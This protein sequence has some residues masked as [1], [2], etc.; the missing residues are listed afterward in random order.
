MILSEYRNAND[1]IVYFPSH[2]YSVHTNYKAFKRGSVRCP[3]DKTVMGIACIGIGKY[4]VAEND[5]KHT[6]AYMRWTDMLRRV[7]EL[8][9]RTESYYRNGVRVSDE[10]LCFNNF[11]DW[12][13][14][15][16]GKYDYDEN[17]LELDKDILEKNNN[18]YCPDKCVLATK[19]INMLF[20]KSK[21]SRGAMPLG[22][23]KMGNKY[24]ARMK[25]NGV[26]KHLGTYETIEE[27]F[28]SYKEA[29]EGHI[30]EVAETCKHRI[31]DKLYKAMINY[32]VEISD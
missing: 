11:A 9:Y 30:K 12:Y 24:R 4:K 17:E 13:Y 18:I 19:E 15:E 32:E 28:Q 27:A 21:K 16:I 2:E 8:T 29:K 20:C 14:K 1:I 31:P 3:F 6:I 23:S 22:V 25:V 5:G 10:W 7:Y 26:E